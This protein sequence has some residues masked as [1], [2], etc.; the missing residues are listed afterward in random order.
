MVKM[1]VIMAVA[2]GMDAFSIGIGVGLRGI[3]LIHIARLSFTI[4][5]FH[6]I[7]PVLGMLTGHLVSRL[8]GQ[9]ATFV[10][11]V[12]LVLLGIHMV[13]QS[14]KEEPSSFQVYSW[15]GVIMSALLVSVDAF[16]VGISLG[17]YEANLLLTMLLF[18]FFGGLMAMM[19]LLLGRKVN[20]KL[21][22]FGEFCGG[23]MLAVIGI[24]M[25]F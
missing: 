13:Y 23:L 8:F 2:L 12:V 3:R 22:V 20:A 4:A 25:I 14:L 1:L 18:G 19:G 10:A 24:W 15:W 17:M 9:L 5:V 16:S 7:M 11:G 6:M 21:G